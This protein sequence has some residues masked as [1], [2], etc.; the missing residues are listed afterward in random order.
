MKKLILAIGVCFAINSFAQTN[1]LPKLV[2]KL[3]DIRALPAANAGTEMERK[4]VVSDLSNI[5]TNSSNPS[6]SMSAQLWVAV[7]KLED[8]QCAK[9]PQRTGILSDLLATIETVRVGATNAWQGKAAQI[10][11]CNALLAS[12]QWAAC[13]L[14]VSNLLSNIESYQSETAPDFQTFLLGCNVSQQE[15][16]A[17]TRMLTVIAYAS[18]NNFD[19][20][21]AEVTVIDTKFPQFGQKN[22][23]K[24]K[25]EQLKSG[26]S[27]FIIP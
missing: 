15:I 5:A 23:L 4:V 9:E 7:A 20:A 25:I 6:D 24:T 8:Y 26:V 22:L 14:N 17:E 10:L 2:K 19:A 16:E 27:P 18:E 3:N 12:K 13:R 21:V 11:K 1:E